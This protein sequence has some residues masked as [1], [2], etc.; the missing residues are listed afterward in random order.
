LSAVHTAEEAHAKGETDMR[1][2]LAC[3]EALH[4]QRREFL[5]AVL[6]YNLQIA[7]YAT[8]VAAPGVPSDKFVAMLIRVRQPDRLGSLPGRSGGSST[9]SGATFDTTREFGIRPGGETRP[10]SDGWT[11]S[12]LRSVENETPQSQREPQQREQQSL[13]EPQ[14]Q[15]NPP[16]QPQRPDPFAPS[17]GGD[18]YGNYGDRYGNPSR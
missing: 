4:Q 2:V 18:R 12:N 8:A 13:R 5:D 9:S 10:S 11:P 17:S 7:E 14:F 3:H 16:A 15:D 6:D 1:T